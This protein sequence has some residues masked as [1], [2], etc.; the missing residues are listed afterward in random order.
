M[1][2]ARSGWTSVP[3]PVQWSLPA[4]VVTSARSRAELRADAT[5]SKR[6]VGSTS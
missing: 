4:G 5:K 6:R 3:G 2:E 1:D